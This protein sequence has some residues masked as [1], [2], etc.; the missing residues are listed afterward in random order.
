M[1]TEKQNNMSGATEAHE[2]VMHKAVGSIKWS[3]L[4]EAV[5]RGTGPIVLVILARVLA[6]EV[7][8]VV[9]VATIA[10]SFFGYVMGR[11]VKQSPDPNQ[12]KPG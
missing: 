1:P 10:I 3:M 4:T 6:P 7:F 5:S 2:S 9:A 8:G 11:W 12:G